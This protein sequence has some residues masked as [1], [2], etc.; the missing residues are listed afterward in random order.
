MLN[1]NQSPIGTV[2]AESYLTIHDEAVFVHTSK[3]ILDK[4]KQVIEKD[5]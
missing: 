4:M 1:G 5:K 3:A 2:R